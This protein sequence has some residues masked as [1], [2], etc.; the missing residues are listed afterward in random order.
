MIGFAAI[1]FCDNGW[2]GLFAQGLGTSM[3]Q[4]GNICKKPQ[5]WIA[6]TLAAAICG[7]ISTLVFKLECNGVSAGMGICGLV[8]PLGIISAMN[9]G[10]DMWLGIL[11]VCFVLPAVLSL[12]FNAVL[13]KVGWVKNGDMKLAG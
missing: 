12:L 6:P 2:G 5:I 4:M 9:S 10:A 8:G 1:S 11:L 13:K 3:L 7:P